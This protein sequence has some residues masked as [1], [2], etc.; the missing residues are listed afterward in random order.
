MNITALL[1]QTIFQNLHVGFAKGPLSPPPRRSRKYDGI[2]ENGEILFI[3]DLS[4]IIA[5]G[6]F[7]G[8]KT[9]S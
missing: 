5:R 2:S 6:I 8:L 9:L 1:E 4:A 7:F 3:G